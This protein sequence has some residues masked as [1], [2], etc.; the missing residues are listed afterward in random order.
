MYLYNDKHKRKNIKIADEN[1]IGSGMYGSVYKLN[2]ETCIKI[3][4]EVGSI[5]L[6]ILKKI[7]ELK[8]PNYYKILE[9]YYNK[10]N[11]LKAHIMEYYQ[12]KKSI[13]LQ[14]QQNTNR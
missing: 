9:F 10:N 12:K 2:E 7:N 13:Y 5:E 8:L 11:I 14:C 6:N 1:K 3:Y 4:D